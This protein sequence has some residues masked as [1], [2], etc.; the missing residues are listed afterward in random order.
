M[1]DPSTIYDVP[2]DSLAGRHNVFSDALITI[3]KINEALSKLEHRLDEMETE[4]RQIRHTL[5]NMTNG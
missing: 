2:P 1:T 4:A 3:H 5:E